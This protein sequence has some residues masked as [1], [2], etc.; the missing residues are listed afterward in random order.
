MGSN[1]SLG[2][3]QSRIASNPECGIS[4]PRTNSNK[5]TQGR[6]CKMLQ[7]YET[8]SLTFQ[9]DDDQ[10]AKIKTKAK[11][12]AGRADYCLECKNTEH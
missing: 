10:L 12:I 9:F 8:S 11:T 6:E 3:G 5:A 2:T 1:S 4:A 7:C